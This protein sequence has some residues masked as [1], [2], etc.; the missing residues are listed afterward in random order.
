[1]HGYGYGAIGATSISQY[2][3]YQIRVK[4]ILKPFS[5][6][7]ILDYGGATGLFINYFTNNH[8]C[9]SYDQSNYLTKIGI[10]NF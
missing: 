8:L 3:S 2:K 6:E 10:K 5:R 9:Y 1:M 4:N 7:S